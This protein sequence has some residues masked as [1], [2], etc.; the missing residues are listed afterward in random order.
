MQEI[1]LEEIENHLK[2]AIGER[3]DF[4]PPFWPYY[5]EITKGKQRLFFFGANHSHD[6]ENEQYPILEEKWNEF[7]GKVDPQKTL[8]VTEGGGNRRIMNSKGEAILDGA[9]GSFIAYLGEQSEIASQSFEIKNKDLN[10]MLAKIFPKRFV[11][12]HWFCNYANS[13]FHKGKKYEE[14]FEQKINRSLKRDEVDLMW[15]DIDFTYMG[16]LEVYKELFPNESLNEND[17]NLF[18]EFAR[19]NGKVETKYLPNPFIINDISRKAT[20]MRDSYVVKGIYD[21]WQEGFSMFISF[22]SGHC[23]EQEPVLREIL[24]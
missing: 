14:T 18:Y 8:I 19:P 23:I 10:N 22:G 2:K 17:G 7:V 21:K 6:P 3:K 16:M 13:W 9:E 20:L 4:Q 1:S 12:F 5:F 24:K 15:S 11:V